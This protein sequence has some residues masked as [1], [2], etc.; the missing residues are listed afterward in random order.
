MSQGANVN[1]KEMLG[2]TALHL[3]VERKNIRIVELLLSQS[4]IDINIKGIDE[5]T[6]LQN[7]LYNGYDEI[8]KLILAHNP[9]IKTA[10]IKGNTVIHL[11]LIGSKINLI[12][13]LVK[14]GADI[15]ACNKEGFTAL[16]MA[17]D[18]GHVE[19]YKLLLEH[20]ADSTITI[21]GYTARKLYQTSCSEKIKEFEAAEREVEVHRYKSEEKVEAFIELRK[22][23][24]EPTDKQLLE[25]Q[26]DKTND[27]KEKKHWVD[28]IAKKPKLSEADKN[29]AYDKQQPIAR[30]H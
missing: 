9:D 12:P 22:R 2:D 11:C 8:A 6:P 18:G 25:K 28:I 14:R 26:T 1:A 24:L 5:Q 4:S 27:K 7:A 30:Y 16:H 13:L 21:E 10:D 15:N 3:A 23:K 29:L 20:G 17:A 19:G